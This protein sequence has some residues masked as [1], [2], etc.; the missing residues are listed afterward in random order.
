MIQRRKRRTRS[1]YRYSN[2]YKHLDKLIKTC[3]QL[4]AVY[5]RKIKK[6]YQVKARRKINQLTKQTQTETL[7]L[8]CVF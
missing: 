7:H 8:E 2:Y 3:K 6:L 5:K 4:R 1:V